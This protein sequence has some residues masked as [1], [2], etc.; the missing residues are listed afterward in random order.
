MKIVTLELEN[1]RGV[2]QARIMFNGRSAVIYG[3]NGMGKSAILEVCNLLFSRIFKSLTS[4]DLGHDKDYQIREA[5]IKIGADRTHI[6]MVL[7]LEG[8]EY[9]YTRSALRSGA[10]THAGKYLEKIAENMRRIYLGTY[11]P[12]M[13]SDESDES[14]KEEKKNLVLNDCNMPIYATYG[15]NRYV[16]DRIDKA[17]K[18]EK[19]W[20]KMEAWSEDR[21]SVV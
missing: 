3:I 17:E 4:S 9:T 20:G 8:T 2:E 11:E 1:F 16:I 6:G 12:V 5:D 10:R 7:D 18:D 21:K 19:L 14:E 13:E 15:V